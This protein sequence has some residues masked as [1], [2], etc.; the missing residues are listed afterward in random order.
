MLKKATLSLIALSSLCDHRK[1]NCA[2]EYIDAGMIEPESEAAQESFVTR[3]P[4]T[5][6][7]IR[8]QFSSQAKENALYFLMLH[9]RNPIELYDMM[10]EVRSLTRLEPIDG[11][12]FNVSLQPLAVFRAS[13]AWNFGILG[14]G[15]YFSLCVSMFSPEE[16]SYGDFVTGEYSGARGLTVIGSRT[17]SKNLGIVL[18][19]EGSLKS[20]KSFESFGN[21]LYMLEVRK[22]LGPAHVGVF[23]K[24]NLLGLN[25]LHRTS[26]ALSYGVQLG[27]T[28]FLV[29]RGSRILK[30]CEAR[31]GGSM[32]RTSTSCVADTFTMLSIL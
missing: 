17:L 29:E 25:F 2:E 14:S 3:P 11:L 21:A 28:V 13:G 20:L 9:S 6:R 7:E 27:I 10:R 16:D 22:L 12:R 5:P 31:Q 4:N 23:R 8:E 15:R 1:F 19:G 26:P 18:K 30:S 32:R 24:E